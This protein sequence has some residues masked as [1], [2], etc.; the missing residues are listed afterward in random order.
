M[1]FWNEART[2]VA[3]ATGEPATAVI[4]PSPSTVGARGRAV[5]DHMQAAA[6][7]GDRSQGRG[8]KFACLRRRCGPRLWSCEIGLVLSWSILAAQRI[9]PVIL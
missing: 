2:V 4:L 5:R 8:S 3:A 9:E 7:I 6:A 1:Y